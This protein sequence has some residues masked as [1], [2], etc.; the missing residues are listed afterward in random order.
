MDAKEQAALCIGGPIWND[1]LPDT[2]IT[3]TWCNKF[4]VPGIYKYNG[5]V[6]TISTVLWFPLLFACFDKELFKL[7]HPKILNRI[8]TAYSLIALLPKEFNPVQ[9]ILLNV[10]RINKHF[11]TDNLLVNTGSEPAV[12]TQMTKIDANNKGNNQKTTFQLIYCL[13]KICKL[14]YR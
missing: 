9:H 8:N 3:D 11:H 10:Y 1:L 6:N 4:V 2:S 5:T 12:I 14:N 13:Y 7:V